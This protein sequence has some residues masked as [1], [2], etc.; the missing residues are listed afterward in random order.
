MIFFP[1]GD[2]ADAGMPG[3]AV[4]IPC[5]NAALT[6]GRTIASV[7]AQ[8]YP[9]T[10]IIVVDDGSQD[11]SVD[12]IL[13]IAPEAILVTGP[14][15]GACHARNQGLHLATGDYVMFLDADDEI[16]GDYL[17]NGTVMAQAHR[18]DLIFTPLVRMF[19]TQ[20]IS[21]KSDISSNVMPQD[22][23]ESWLRGV[24]VNPA[25]T[26]WRRAFVQEI[27]G[28]NESTLINQDA[29]IVLRALL[30][31]PVITVNP[32]GEGIYHVLNEGSLSSQKSEAK[33]AN[34][35]ETLERL[36]ALA[37]GT[38]FA[39]RTSGIEDTLYGVARM[40][41]RAGWVDVGRRALTVL[42]RRGP[43]RHRGSM[44]HRIVA[45]MIGLERKVLLWGS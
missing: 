30:C 39:T 1:D 40:A 16:R 12:T 42:G 37:E 18:A 38:P 4:V 27:G 41:M 10:E 31:N 15:L 29:E 9:N 23:F 24:Q 44:Q 8:G 33:L 2:R 21:R 26:L 3:V 19:G 5:Y 14:N 34:Y 20:V 36:L 11:D 7:R 6:I 28:W 45:G 13:R 35:V 32:H 25:A 22:L 17:R 43:V